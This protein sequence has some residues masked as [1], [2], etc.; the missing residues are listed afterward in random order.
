MEYSNTELMSRLLDIVNEFLERIFTNPKLSEAE[1]SNLSKEYENFIEEKRGSYYHSSSSPNDV[2]QKLT[3]SFIKYD[4]IKILFDDSVA[5]SYL[6]I[7]KVFRNQWAHR[8]PMNND[9]IRYACETMLRLSHL[10]KDDQAIDDLG[11][12]FAYISEKDNPL[13]GKFE[14]T[15][16]DEGQIDSIHQTIFQIIKHYDIITSN[17]DYSFPI[18]QEFAR[19]L[20]LFFSYPWEK[21]KK[22]YAVFFKKIREEYPWEKWYESML[23]YEYN[24]YCEL[25]YFQAA[26]SINDDVDQSPNGDGIIRDL[27]SFAIG[28]EFHLQELAIHDIEIVSI[29]IDFINIVRNEL[30]SQ[31]LRNK[32]FKLIP[33]LLDGNI[34]E[35]DYALLTG[36]IHYGL[37]QY[38]QKTTEK[39]G[40]VENIESRDSTPLV[41][42]GLGE[43]QENGIPNNVLDEQEENTGIIVENGKYPNTIHITDGNISISY[44]Y[45]K[46]KLILYHYPEI[47][48]FLN[49]EKIPELFTSTYKGYE[50]I[51]LPS[52]VNPDLM[53]GKQKGRIIH[54]AIKEVFELMSKNGC[55]QQA[56]IE[57]LLRIYNEKS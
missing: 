6:N 41:L 35:D 9:D 23:Y 44:G 43:N 46:F 22:Y 8:E 17:I 26:V 42:T 32:G 21:Y 25:D 14:N 18:G 11:D 33:D 4:L 48:K 40:K 50:V 19:L 34:S 36:G 12:I 20:I 13:L 16:N 56:E 38:I 49:G 39:G 24:G 3:F 29:I 47:L 15:Y 10:A 27:I 45:R 1:R 37:D 55:F 28:D 2:F 57:E 31:D 52:N 53:F 7:L 30:N 51:C 5:R 54:N